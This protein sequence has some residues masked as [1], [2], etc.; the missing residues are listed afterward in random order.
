LATTTSKDEEA[1][2]DEHGDGILDNACHESEG[3]HDFYHFEDNAVVR[4]LCVLL[5]SQAMKS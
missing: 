2:N 3:A 1:T 4:A 5:W